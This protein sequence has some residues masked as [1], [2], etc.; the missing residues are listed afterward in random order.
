MRINRLVAGLLATG[1]AVP[2]AGAAT[3][4]P[5]FLAGRWTTGPVQN[6]TRAEHEQTVFRTDG[7][8]ATEHRGKALAVGFWQVTD[9]QLD[10]HILT[11]E[12][13]LAPAMQEQLPGDYHALHIKG[14]VFDVSDNS[15]RMVQNISGELQGLDLVRCP[16]P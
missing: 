16:A 4:S 1:V 9:D 2:A 7:T 6:C 12:A 3:L 13:S 8:F 5:E 11:T 15:F 10:M 14:L